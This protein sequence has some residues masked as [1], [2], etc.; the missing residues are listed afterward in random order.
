MF[1]KLAVATAK[2]EGRQI[3]VGRWN[4]GRNPDG[5]TD[6]HHSAE[7]VCGNHFFADFLKR[8]PCIR[9]YRTSTMSLMRAKKATPQVVVLL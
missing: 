3:N 8:Y 4:G 1:R 7:I 2:I 9:N 6:G 5:T